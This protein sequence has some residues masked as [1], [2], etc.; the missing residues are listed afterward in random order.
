MKHNVYFEGRVQS[1]GLETESGHA[2]IGVITPG[3]YTFS[4]SLEE[5]MKITSGSLNVKLPGETWN[6]VEAGKEFI[7][8]ANSSFDV[9]AP[10]DVAYICYYK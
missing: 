7:V 8:Q 3:K 1:L 2:T 5:R 10:R 9:E 6:K 4:T